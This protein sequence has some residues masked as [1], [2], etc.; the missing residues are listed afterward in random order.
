MYGKM[1][2]RLF[3]AVTDPLQEME[4]RNY[5]TAQ[6]LLVAA[7]QDCEEIYL[8]GEEEDARG[9]AAMGG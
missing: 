7:Q 4:N 5:G 9:G 3:N 1:Y 6:Q 8:D 2:Y